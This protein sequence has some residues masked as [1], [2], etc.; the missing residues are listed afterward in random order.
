MPKNSVKTIVTVA[1][2]IAVEVV[3]NR[4]CSINTESLKI[5]FGFVPIAVCGMLYGPVWAAAAGFL[6]DF[7][8]AI[9]FPIGPY[10]PGF[11]FTSALTG[12]MFGL[13]LRRRPAGL[14]SICACAVVNNLIF[15]LLLNT[16]WISVLYGTPYLELLPVR[17]MQSAIMIP[18]QIAVLTVMRRPVA[19]LAQMRAA[20]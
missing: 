4:F 18:V 16:L 17:F 13:L 2:L 8:G 11:S 9:L 10:F 20:S 12:A 3:L 1:L 15:G 6:S 5:G 7:T 19:R 14:P